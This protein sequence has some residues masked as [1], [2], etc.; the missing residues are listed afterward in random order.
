M[1]ST[2]SSSVCLLYSGNGMDMLFSVHIGGLQ[3]SCLQRVS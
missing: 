2:V 3:C 1:S